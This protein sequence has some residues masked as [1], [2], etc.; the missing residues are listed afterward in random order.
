M[1]HT[2]STFYFL[3]LVVTA[4]AAPKQAPPEYMDVK[5]ACEAHP[6]FPLVGEYVARTG[7]RALQ[8]NMLKDGTFL[9]AEYRKGLPGVGW[10]GSAIVS[11]VKT[12][13]ELRG[14]LAGFHKAER[15]SV[16]MG[17]ERPHHR[18]SQRYADSR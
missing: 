18:A 12:A 6:D 3:F 17:E 2:V 9:V 16:T 11:S 14:I 4:F 5:S 1:K 13:E 15:T 7:D 10:D 8:A